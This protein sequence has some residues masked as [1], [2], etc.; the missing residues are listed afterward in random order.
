MLLFVYFCMLAFFQQQMAISFDLER[1]RGWEDLGKTIFSA[2]K[3]LHHYFV[4]IIL[5]TFLL[6]LL[7]I[8]G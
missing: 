3:V 5:N 1:D 4:D 8:S 2:L 6:I 7:P